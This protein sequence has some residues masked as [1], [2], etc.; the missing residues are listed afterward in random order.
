MTLYELNKLRKSLE[1]A[2]KL[3]AKINSKKNLVDSASPNMSGMPPSDGTS[4][5]TIIASYLDDEAKLKKI[6]SNIVLSNRKALEYIDSIDDEITKLI[7]IYR[8]QNGYTW[9][10]VAMEIGGGNTKDGVYKKVK[11]Y[12]ENH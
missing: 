6:Y 3:Q 10:K 12:L 4:K 8:F 11:R 1:P 7:F 2:R 9:V 5:D